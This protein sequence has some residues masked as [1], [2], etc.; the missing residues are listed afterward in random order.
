M[1]QLQTDLDAANTQI[2]Q[3]QEQIDE[4]QSSKDQHLAEMKTGLLSELGEKESIIDELKK[5][6]NDLTDQL[7][8][9]DKEIEEK[10]QA[11]DQADKNLEEAKDENESLKK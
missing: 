5:T 10:W 8:Q 9:K 1:Q 2:Q 4:I 3:K 6:N 11:I 7:A